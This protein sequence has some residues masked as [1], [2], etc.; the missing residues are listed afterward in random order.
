MNQRD[1]NLN[2]LL[3]AR[4]DF[5]ELLARTIEENSMLASL[6]A[7]LLKAAAGQRWSIQVAWN[8]RDNLSELLNVDMR[9]VLIGAWNKSVVLRRYLDAERYPPDQT[10]IVHLSDH[11]IR[12]EHRPYLEISINGLFER[13]EFSLVLELK[14]KGFRLKIQGGE[15]HEI[16]NGD[17][18]G[19]VTLSCGPALLWET[20]TGTVFLPGSIKLEPPRKIWG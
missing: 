5:S 1:V 4:P 20:E 12:S 7:P 18:Q 9:D 17:C 15:I 6:A 14:L 16:L 8:A 19:R 2:G 10:V 3:A 11:S 13:L